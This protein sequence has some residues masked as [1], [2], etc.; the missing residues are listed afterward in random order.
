MLQPSTA[1]VQ[2]A[3]NWHSAATEEDRERLRDWRAAFTSALAAA[4]ASGRGDDIAREGAL[5][6]P[7]AA[8]GGPIPNGSYRCRVIKVGAQSGML[9]FVAYPYF[10]CRVEQSGPDQSFA[11]LGGS[12]RHV[13]RI[14]PNDQLRQVFLGTLMLADESRA[15]QYGV[16]PE[17]D[18][19]GFVERIE[20]NRWRMLLR[21]T[22]KCCRVCLQ[23]A[24]QDH[25]PE[26]VKERLES[27]AAVDE[28][29]VLLERIARDR[30]HRRGRC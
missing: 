13:G 2:P 11:K 29:T 7:D 18:V 23:H 12:Q 10:T 5:L 16:D 26:A 8:L 27:F 21:R 14:F 17:R 15:M 28:R 25:L 9:D 6:D 3:R 30:S 1:V 20:P 19:V 4:R 24:Y 22:Q